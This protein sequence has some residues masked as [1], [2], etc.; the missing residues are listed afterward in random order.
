[1]SVI[2]SRSTD[3]LPTTS[4]Y[5]AH[6]VT[7]VSYSDCGT[8]LTCERW[9]WT[10][11]VH[12]RCARAYNCRPLSLDSTRSS[13][14][15]RRDWL[16]LCAHQKAAQWRSCAS[17]EGSQRSSRDAHSKRNVGP[18]FNVTVSL[19]MRALRIGRGGKCA[20]SARAAGASNRDASSSAA[21]STEI[22]LFPSGVS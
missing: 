1:M 2:G 6:W 22:S 4:A 14:Q 9:R 16:L 10:A 12:C 18:C 11:R 15:A 3:T 7:G 17:Q 5:F 19:C 8:P 13:R 20:R 21:A